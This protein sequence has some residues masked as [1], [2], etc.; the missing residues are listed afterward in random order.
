MTDGPSLHDTRDHSFADGF[1]VS[2]FDQSYSLKEMTVTLRS[3]GPVDHEA[4]KPLL[5]HL[6]GLVGIEGER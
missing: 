4:L 1:L 3:H 5:G 6:V 2:S